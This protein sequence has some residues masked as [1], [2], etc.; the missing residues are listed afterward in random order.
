MKAG[1]A[2][3]PSDL[4]VEMIVASWEIGIGVM[5]SRCVGWKRNAG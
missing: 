2:A 5:V 4:S 3:R 1:K